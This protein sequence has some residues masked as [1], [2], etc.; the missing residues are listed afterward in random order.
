ML[1]SSQL[2]VYIQLIEESRGRAAFYRFRNQLLKGQTFE[3]ELEQDASKFIVEGVVEFSPYV[4]TH[5]F[6]QEG[7]CRK[8]FSIFFSKG[9]T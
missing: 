4:L 1:V 7:H 5:H 8:I 3:I 6:V 9:D 2:K